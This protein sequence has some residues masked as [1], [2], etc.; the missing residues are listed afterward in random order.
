MTVHRQCLILRR[1]SYAA[2]PWGLP[3]V[4]NALRVQI[5]FKTVHR[6]GITEYF[7][8]VRNTELFVVAGDL[9]RL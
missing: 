2:V 1:G 9:V 8:V 6:N 3:G 7:R 5:R 4:M